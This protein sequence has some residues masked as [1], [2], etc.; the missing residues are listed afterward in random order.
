MQVITVLC[1]LNYVL[2]LNCSY[3]SYKYLESKTGNSSANREF[4]LYQKNQELKYKIAECE[5]QRNIKQ[6]KSTEKNSLCK[7]FSQD[8]SK[9]MKLNAL[10]HGKSI[11]NAKIAENKNKKS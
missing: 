4:Y 5:R 1:F 7:Q 3:E 10:Y 2:F 8:S 9:N 6:K 11:L